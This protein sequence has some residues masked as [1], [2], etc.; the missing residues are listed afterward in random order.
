MSRDIGRL[1]RILM[2]ETG[3]SEEQARKQVEKQLDLV[4]KTKEAEREG[5]RS[6]SSRQ[7]RKSRPRVGD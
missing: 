5:G 3:M 4:E 1:V 2:N 7:R 6:P